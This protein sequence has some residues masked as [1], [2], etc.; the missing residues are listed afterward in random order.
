MTLSDYRQTKAWQGALDLGP[1]LLR[2]AE[3][4]PAAEEMGLSLALRQAAIELP[5]GIAADL[6][7]DRQP[8]LDQAL[9]VTA[10]LELID[11]VYPALDTATARAAADKLLE[12]LTGG[13]FTEGSNGSASAAQVAPAATSAPAPAAE[14]AKFSITAQPPVPEAAATAQS[15]SAAPEAATTGSGTAEEVHVQPNSGQ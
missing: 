9:K 15:L 4:L 6:L 10:A 12:R 3:E 7:Q 13:D 8:R 2:L 11:Q 14:V 5:A 1:Q